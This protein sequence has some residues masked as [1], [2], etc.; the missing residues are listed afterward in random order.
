MRRSQQSLKIMR[1]R[2]GIRIRRRGAGR[3]P[4]PQIERARRSLHVRRRRDDRYRLHSTLAKQHGRKQRD[5]EQ[6]NRRSYAQRAECHSQSLSL[7][8]PS[9][10]DPGRIDESI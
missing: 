5:R 3:K 6:S 2:R 7:S 10:L 1:N 9:S 4:A 8:L